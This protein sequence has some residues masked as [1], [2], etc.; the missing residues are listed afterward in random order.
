MKHGNLK[1]RFAAL[2]TPLKKQIFIRFAL[3]IAAS[4]A[5]AAIMAISGDFKFALPCLIV[6]GFLAVSGG[7]LLKEALNGRY[8]CIHGICTGME[9]SAIRKRLKAIRVDV[10]GIPL[11]IRLK[12]K[13]RKPNIGD[14][15][16]LYASERAPVYEQDGIKIICSYYDIETMKGGKNDSG[17]KNA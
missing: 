17:Q 16:R 3:C 5:F 6:C 7:M 13:F 10:G 8:I 9:T 11:E 2:P 4:A 14:E 12:H 15:I 1:K